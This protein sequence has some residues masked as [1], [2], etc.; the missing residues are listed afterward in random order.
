M[1]WEL[2]E[3]TTYV[4]KYIDNPETYDIQL[5]Y[6]LNQLIGRR[7]NINLKPGVK[8]SPIFFKNV[9]LWHIDEQYYEEDED[10]SDKETRY[11]IASFKTEKNSMYSHSV[12]LNQIES[13]ELLD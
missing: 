10:D 5:I 4:N 3:I 6:E 1:A 7:M 9:Y 2:E 12:Y 8:D 13:Y 11:I